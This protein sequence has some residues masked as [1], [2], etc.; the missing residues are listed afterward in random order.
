LLFTLL[1]A[2]LSLSLQLSMYY[3]NILYME[4]EFY[5]SLR[6]RAVITAQFFLEQDEVTAKRHHELQT[7]YLHILPDEVIRI[8]DENDQMQFIEENIDYNFPSDILKKVRL[9]KE[10]TYSERG[11]RQTLGLVYDNGKQVY[12]ILASAV[13]THLIEK[14]K[15]MR[16]ML[17]FGFF[18]SIIVVVITA[19][20]FVKKALLPFETIVNQINAISA[21]TLNLRLSAENR[22]DEVGRL[23]LTFNSFIARL[24]DA[25]E[26]QKAFVNN[27]SHELRTPLTAII[28]EAEIA[29]SKERTAEEYRAVVESNLAEA[30][31]LKK[32]T[33]NLL[34]LA[35]T[36][37]TTPNNLFSDR[38]QIDELIMEVYAEVNKEMPDSQIR[39]HFNNIPDNSNDFMVLTNHDLLDIA[40]KN[41]IENACKFSD[42]REVQVSISSE[43]SH[44]KIQVTD[45]GM[46]I[47]EE[48]IRKI[49]LPFYRATNARH[50]PGSGIGLFLVEKIIKLH[51]GT[52]EIDS[53]VGWGTHVTVTLPTFRA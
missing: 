43:K 32:L 17:V 7:K 45:T 13:N 4:R 11:D 48:E 3:V 27:A 28:G 8:Y 41:I 2:A 51:N 25:F 26:M 5:T 6:E 14:R 38:V 36:G 12:V 16:K 52:L 29:L 30:E 1:I 20:F 53:K 10:V 50:R 21:T 24:E 18:A 46:G 15:F 35:Q 49:T 31:K 34:L 42:Y 47:E 23:A 44:V 9:R 22:T 33:N 37:S 40:L 19:F 39:I